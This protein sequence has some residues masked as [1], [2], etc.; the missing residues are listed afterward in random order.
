MEERARIEGRDD[1]NIETF[2]KRYV[3]Y[4]K[5]Q[6]PIVE[7]YRK[8]GLVSDIDGSESKENVMN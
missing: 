3:T 7:K 4:E 5:H 6:L 8:L 1:D 2:K